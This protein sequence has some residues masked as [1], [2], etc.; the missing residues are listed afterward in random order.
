MFF[1]GSSDEAVEV[2]GRHADVYALWG[3]TQAQVRETVSRVRAAAARH[4]RR[5]GFSL[6]LRPVIADTEEAAWQRA[7][8]IVERVRDLRASA[9]AKLA[10]HT[11]PQRRLAAPA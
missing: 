3:E 10:G 5:P 8:E 6:S 7:A 11:P 1:G 2:S 4:G 9:G